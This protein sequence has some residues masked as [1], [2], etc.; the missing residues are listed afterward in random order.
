M[1]ALQYTRT[2]GD[3]DFQKFIIS[4]LIMYFTSVFTRDGYLCVSYVDSGWDGLFT[5][6]M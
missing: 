6:V 5:I 1:D 2:C 4:W 3:V